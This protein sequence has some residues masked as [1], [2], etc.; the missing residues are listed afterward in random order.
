M[1]QETGEGVLRQGAEQGRQPRRGRGARR[2]GA[3]G[4]AD[5]RREGHAAARR[6]AAVARRSRRW[7]A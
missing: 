1:V 3:G 5:G 2:G 6:H 4:R 7:A